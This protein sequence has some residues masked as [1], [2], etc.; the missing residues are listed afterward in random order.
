MTQLIALQQQLQTIWLSVFSRLKH[1]HDLDWSNKSCNALSQTPA[2]DRIAY[3]STNW[4][5]NAAN[6]VANQLTRIAELEVDIAKIEATK[7]DDKF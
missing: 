7:A 2:A 1:P 6:A 5:Q 3:V 4:G